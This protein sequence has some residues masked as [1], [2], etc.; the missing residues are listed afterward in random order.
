MLHRN[1]AVTRA[2]A[3][4]VVAVTLAPAAASAHFDNLPNKIPP[5]PLNLT[6]PH[7]Q[8]VSDGSGFDWGD[9]GIGAAAGI[10]LSI[11]GVAGR[12]ALRRRERPANPSP[13]T[14]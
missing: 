4:A 2:L 3:I 14:R 9:A 7:V 11:L 8:V 5:V 12:S 10:G 13:A 6:A 1:N